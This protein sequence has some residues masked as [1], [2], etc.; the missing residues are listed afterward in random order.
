MAQF[1]LKISLRCSPEHKYGK[2]MC[3]L[4]KMPFQ[5]AMEPNPGQ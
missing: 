1:K 3:L 2:E 4:V 5:D